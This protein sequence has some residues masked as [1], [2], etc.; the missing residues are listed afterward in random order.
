MPVRKYRR[1]EDMPSPP[2]AA[3]PLEG[4]ASACALAALCAAL[5]PSGVAER[6]VRKFRS[7]EEADAHRQ[8]WEVG[9]SRR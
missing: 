8:A 9:P 6:G 3:S 2:P 4:L 7:V 5:G 1:V